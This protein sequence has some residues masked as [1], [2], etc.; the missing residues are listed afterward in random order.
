MIRKK[1]EENKK[2][3]QEQINQWQASGKSVKIW[4]EENNILPKT[5]Y[6]RKQVLLKS[7]KPIKLT[8]NSFVELSNNQ[9]CLEL[10]IEYKNFKLK[11]KELPLSEIAN[12]LKVIK[13]L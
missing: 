1:P 8:P 13:T 2:L 5:F 11:V 3:W 4:C 6:H 10:E 7:Q 9:S 12:F